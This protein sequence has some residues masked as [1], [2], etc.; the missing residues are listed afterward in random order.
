VGSGQPPNDIADVTLR[1]AARVV[2]KSE[3][4][5]AALD[6]MALDL[7]RLTA[8][9]QTIRA[10][11]EACRSQLGR[12]AGV[13]GVG[14]LIVAIGDLQSRMTEIESVC[15]TLEGCGGEFRAMLQAGLAQIRAFAQTEG[16]TAAA[17]ART[18]LP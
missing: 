17:D 10:Q 5:L 1:R 4:S 14:E 8:G 3:Q 18:P 12:L 9:L 7:R 2:P 11:Q 6:H 15:A 16:L 13:E